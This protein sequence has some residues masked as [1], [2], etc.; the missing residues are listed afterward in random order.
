M[1]GVPTVAPIGQ[2]KAVALG[3]IVEELGQQLGN[4]HT[5]A[6]AIS[7]KTATAGPDKPP[8]TAEQGPSPSLN[9]RARSLAVSA[10]DLAA[11]LCE[12]NN[13]L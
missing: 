12:I 7:H 6:D 5:T 1:S 2:A 3:D 8:V 9:A 13:A 4:C 10:R 11:K